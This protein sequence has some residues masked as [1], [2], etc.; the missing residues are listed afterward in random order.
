MEFYLNGQKTEITL[1]NEKNVKE[2]LEAFEL[3]CEKN[4]AT[5]IGV[6]ID[7]KQ[8]PADE[9][10]SFFPLELTALNTINLTTVAASDIIAGL[11][12]VRKNALNLIGAMQEIPL[13]LQKNQDTEA[14]KII[15]NFAD[16]F[17]FFCHIITLSQLF[18][19]KF[20][21]VISTETIS[22]LLNELLPI[23]EEFKN[24]LEQKDTILIGDLSEYEIVP[25]L[26]KISTLLENV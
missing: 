9:L 1:E 6:E 16:F 12:D 25:H 18:P 15:A 13:L 23:I 14:N 24:A 4:E 7:G 8:I 20:N 11:Q 19:E 26:E 22:T 2:F 21:Q 17:D 10:D 3:E 5:I